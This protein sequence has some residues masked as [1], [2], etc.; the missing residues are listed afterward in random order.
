MELSEDWPKG[1]YALPRPISGCP[2]LRKTEWHYGYRLHDAHRLAKMYNSTEPKALHHLR[3][4][5]SSFYFVEEF[6]TK[7]GR[8]T[9]E[10]NFRLFPAGKYCIYKVGANCPKGFESGSLRFYENNME[11]YEREWA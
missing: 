11:P 1:S 6:C 10:R 5:V 8:S 9:N 7:K 4:S 2:T 3:N